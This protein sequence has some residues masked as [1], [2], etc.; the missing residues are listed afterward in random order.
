MSVRRYRLIARRGASHHGPH[1]V[2]GRIPT[3]IHRTRG[4]LPLDANIADDVAELGPGSFESSGGVVA[5]DCP[6]WTA[7][8]GRNSSRSER[9]MNDVYGQPLRTEKCLRTMV[10]GPN[11][12]NVYGHRLRL[13]M[14][15]DT[16]STD[17]L[18]YGHTHTHTRLRTIKQQLST[19]T[20]RWLT[21]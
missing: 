16:S 20:L 8:H 18:V 3:G 5:A 2:A 11:N 6:K 10:Y 4:G 21:R 9:A 15:K 17:S 12:V 1:S 13:Q 14:S 19:D 7:D